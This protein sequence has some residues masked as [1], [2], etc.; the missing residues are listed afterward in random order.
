MGLPGRRAHRAVADDLLRLTPAVRDEV[1]AHC[2]AGVPE[3]ACGLLGGS[4][5]GDDVDAILCWPGRN[6]AASATLY[7]LDPAD[8]L[9]ADREA[10]GKGLEIVGV[11][12]SHTHT[13]AYPSPTDVARAPD[14]DWHYLLISLAGEQ[15]ELR[16]FHIREGVISEEP[17]EI[18]SAE[19]GHS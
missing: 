7:E 13:E 17:L 12:H 14:P 10:E 2:L 16:S 8:H 1:I 18:A 9:R 6:L 19:K 5:D 11:F 4:P 15:P 3:E